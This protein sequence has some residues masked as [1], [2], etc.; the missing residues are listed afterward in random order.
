V[1]QLDLEGFQVVSPG[2]LVKT[3]M[4]EAERVIG[5]AEKGIREAEEAIRLAALMWEIYLPEQAQKAKEKKGRLIST[6][7]SKV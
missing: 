7:D 2:Y 6:L 3:S 1:K 4:Q 5:I